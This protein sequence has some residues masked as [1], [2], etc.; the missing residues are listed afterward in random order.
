[1]SHLRVE[2]S[3]HQPSA[4]SFQLDNNGKRLKAKAEG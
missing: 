1:M 4:L 2:K 3:S